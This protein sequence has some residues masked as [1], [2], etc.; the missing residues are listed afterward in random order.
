M[1][2]L[3]VLLGFPVSAEAG[4]VYGQV[5]LNNAPL[6]NGT[7]TLEKGG[8]QVNVKTDQEGRYQIFLAE[9]TYKV[10][11]RGSEQQTIQSHSGQLLQDIVLKGGE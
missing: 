11:F 3:L 6:K 2:V 10:I 9:G 4:K 5:L 7:F 1:A 8:V